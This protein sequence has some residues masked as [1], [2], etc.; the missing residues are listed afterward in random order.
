MSKTIYHNTR[1]LLSEEE[2]EAHEAVREA[3]QEGEVEVAVLETEAEAVLVAEEHEEDRLI[4]ATVEVV[5]G[6]EEEEDEE[7][8]VEE[9]EIEVEETS[10]I[11]AEST[12]RK[13]NPCSAKRR[14]IPKTSP[15]STWTHNL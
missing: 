3:V 14:A 13:T 9:G 5:V 11:R 10:S 6:E 15:C 7:G 8:E 4:E 2:E 12:N 1:W